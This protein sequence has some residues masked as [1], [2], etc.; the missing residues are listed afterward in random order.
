MAL[1]G[2]PV[3]WSNSTTKPE[4][5]SWEYMGVANYKALDPRSTLGRI[6]VLLV[7]KG[8]LAWQIALCFRTACFRGVPE[9]M[10]NSN[11]HNRAG[12]VLETLRLGDI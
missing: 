9:E 3:I 11:D 4:L 7:R 1:Q 8:R 2:F 5:M 12:A 10:L 6:Y